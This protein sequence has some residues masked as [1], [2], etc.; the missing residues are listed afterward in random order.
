MI[1]NFKIGDKVKSRMTGRIGIIVDNEIT[2]N[3]FWMRVN[4]GKIELDI[5]TR[6]LDW[7]TDEEW[8]FIKSM[9]ERE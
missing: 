7:I 6:D 3:R 8:N 9:E 4:F 2:P 1:R 5:P